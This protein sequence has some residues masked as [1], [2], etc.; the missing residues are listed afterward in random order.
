[1]PKNEQP[2][3]PS[4]SIFA[5]AIGRRV[6]LSL[7]DEA[8]VLCNYKDIPPGGGF[9]LFDR[10]EQGLGQRDFY[11]GLVA[12]EDQFFP[13]D[14]GWF[15]IDG[16]GR[17]RNMWPVILHG[18]TTHDHSVSVDEVRQ[19]LP[20]CYQG[21]ASFRS[22]EDAPPS[23]RFTKPAPFANVDLPLPEDLPWPTFNTFLQRGEIL[24][25][26]DG[27]HVWRLPGLVFCT[28][29]VEHAD[30]LPTINDAVES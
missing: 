25:R 11:R 6:H 18:S 15:L 8:R 21:F 16:E 23:D 9:T 10:S 26:E 2:V 12:E 27:L 14:P 3:E 22:Q 19:G 1:M 17:D 30:F 4:D 20:F 7:L 28:G 29:L 5:D 24:E 13:S